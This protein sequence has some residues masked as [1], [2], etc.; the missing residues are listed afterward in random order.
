MADNHLVLILIPHYPL[1]ASIEPR[2]VSNTVLSADKG[3]ALEESI[4]TQRQHQLALQILPIV[5]RTFEYALEDLPQHVTKGEDYTQVGAGL[6]T[7][8]LQWQA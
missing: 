6:Y 2:L 5:Q 4:Q 7:D 8:F 3:V 1:P